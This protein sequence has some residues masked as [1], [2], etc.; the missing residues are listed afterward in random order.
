MAVA[1]IVMQNWGSKYRKILENSGLSNFVSGGYVDDGR[2]VTQTLRKGMRYNHEMKTIEMTEAGREEDE[3]KARWGEP[4]SRRMATICHPIM[5]SINPDLVFTTEVAEDFVNGRLP[6]LD[7][8]MEIVKGE[9]IHSYYEKWMKSPYQIMEKSAMG[10]QQRYSIL[11]NELIRRLSNLHQKIEMTE[12]INTIER[13][14]QQM[15]TSGYSRGQTREAVV[16]GLMGFSRKIVR[17]KR[18]GDDFYRSAAMTLKP[19]LKKKLLERTNWYKDRK[20]DEDEEKGRQSDGRHGCKG[21]RVRDDR[22]IK[23]RNK[24]KAVMFIPYTHGSKLAKQLREIE[25]K[26]EEITGYRMKI[27]ERGGRRLCDLLHKSNP[28]EGKDC[29]RQKCLPC[30]TKQRT[31]KNGNQSCSK[32]SA[33][34][35]TWCVNCEEK[36]MNAQNGSAVHGSGEIT[37]SKYIGETA[38]STHERGL[39]HWNDALSLNPKSHILKHF[40]EIHMGDNLESLESLRFNMKVLRFSKTSFERQIY[41]SVLIQ[42]NRGHNLLNSK[43][44]FNCCAIPRLTMKRQRTEERGRKER[45]RDEKRGKTDGND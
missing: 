19:R 30:E 35:E 21:G 42:E 38:R 13:F 6:S 44:E 31:E 26:M 39:E 22:K 18:K 23:G 16:S 33:V 20:K 28:W 2:Q 36:E 37:L 5:N 43:S 27:E 40:V 12:K 11:S 7:F 15:K 14:I 41:K 10:E 17:K 32:R 9:I 24:I 29:E 3:M 8:T 34:Y 25:M 4:V 45:R 1:R